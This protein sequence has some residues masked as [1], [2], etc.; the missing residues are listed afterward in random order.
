M[1]EWVF[2][3]V[4]HR[5]ANDSW[6]HTHTHTHWI[7]G[8]FKRNFITL[9]T[10]PALNS[11]Y[12]MFNPFGIRAACSMCMRAPCRD[13]RK[14]NRQTFMSCIAYPTTIALHQSRAWWISFTSKNIRLWIACS[15]RARSHEDIKY[16]THRWYWAHR[17]SIATA[18]MLW[19]MFVELS[20]AAAKMR[21]NSFH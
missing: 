3:N 19:R 2:L 18:P 9:K 21:C 10:T 4:N 1:A 14:K 15:V 7:R 6:W 5:M 11:F 20:W 12:F 16:Q 13:Q 17:C 8:C